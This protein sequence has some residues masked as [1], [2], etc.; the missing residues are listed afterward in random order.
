MNVFED[1]VIELK[2]ENLLEDTVMDAARNESAATVHAE[3]ANITDIP[4]DV[5]PA[6]ASE[7]AM[8]EQKAPESEYENTPVAMAVPADSDMQLQGN[9]ETVEIRRPSSERE[10]FKKRAVGEVAS[11]QM[12]EHVLTS[13]EREHMK[14]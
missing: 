4:I 5:P 11:L 9:D 1:L 7:P 14:V 12:V 13:V 2:E 3:P 6:A 10:F 8:G